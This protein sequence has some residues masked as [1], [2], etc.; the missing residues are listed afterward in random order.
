[1]A[2][3]EPG[4]LAARIAADATQLVQMLGGGQADDGEP[5]LDDRPTI[6]VRTEAELRDAMSTAAQV[7][8]PSAGRNIVIEGSIPI[9]APLPYIGEQHLTVRGESPSKPG[10]LVYDGP[11]DETSAVFTIVSSQLTLTD[12]HLVVNDPGND[13]SAGRRIRFVQTKDLG[14]GSAVAVLIYRCSAIA[15]SSGV[16]IEGGAAVVD[17]ADSQFYRCRRYGIFGQRVGSAFLKSSIFEIDERWGEEHAARLYVGSLTAN[18]VKFRNLM[19]RVNAAGTHYHKTSLW[20]PEAPG[21]VNVSECRFSGGPVSYGSRPGIGSEL[22]CDVLHSDCVH[23]HALGGHAIQCAGGVARADFARNMIST[24]RTKWLHI[25]GRGAPMYREPCRDVTWG[26]Q[27][28]NGQEVAG[29]DGVNAVPDQ[30]SLPG[31]GPW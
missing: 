1:M 28:V 5:S 21:G 18:N 25:E 19:E 16:M 2:S 13:R 30:D 29:W 27:R 12:V 24:P 15:P 22:V 4:E 11:G 10:E 9:T 26:P 3:I 6:I 14:D 17:I 7:D 8:A 31:C 23:S 20:V